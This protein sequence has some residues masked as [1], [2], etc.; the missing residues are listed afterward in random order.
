MKPP[1]VTLALAVTAL[2]AACWPGAGEALQ[3]E[4]AAL[5]AGEGWRALSAHLVH[6]GREHLAYDVLALLVLG[7]ACERRGRARMLG[8]LS[9]AALLIPAVV[10]AA[11][12]DLSSYRGLSGLDSA[13]F[14]LL[15]TALTREAL[16]AGQ[17]AR[18][19]LLAGVG[20]LFLAKLLL[21]LDGGG[22]FV[23]GGGFVT[24]PEAH[25]AGA[26]VGVVAALVPGRHEARAALS[27]SAR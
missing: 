9:A 2:L 4:R 26:C 5:S 24:V 17:R 18:V 7:A 22:V 14:A 13:L 19:A 6:F 11:R 1:L 8:A 15:L 12:P 3:W 25:V 27:P 23:R 16:M 21:E 10:A 20:V